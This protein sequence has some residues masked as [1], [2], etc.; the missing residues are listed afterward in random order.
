MTRSAR[1]ATPARQPQPSAAPRPAASSHGKPGAGAAP[2][3]LDNQAM[4]ALLRG[5]ELRAKMYVGAPDDPEERQAEATAER[6]M[7]APEADA[8]LPAASTAGIA[9]GTGGEPL[10]PGLR[11]FY[12]LRLGADFSNVRIY[13]DTAAQAAAA[14][15]GAHAFTL[16]QDIVF[17]AGQ[18]APERAEGRRLLAHELAHVERRLAGADRRGAIARAVDRSRADPLKK[19][20]DSLI[21]FNSRLERMWNEFGLDLPE[22]IAD[23]TPV[24]STPGKN[25]KPESYQDLWRRSVEVEKISQ[26]AAGRTLLS[27]FATDTVSFTKSHLSSQ[28]TRLE[29]LRAEL[30]RTEAQNRSAPPPTQSSAGGV[31]DPARKVSRS[32]VPKPMADVRN[33]VNTATL[34]HFLQSWDSLLRTAPIGVCQ[35]DGSGLL[36]PPGTPPPAP[37]FEPF[38]GPGGTLAA[39]A[40][41]GAGGAGGGA[42]GGQPARRLILF[43]PNKEKDALLTTPGLEFIDNAALEAL[44]RTWRACDEKRAEF[45]ELANTILAED[46]GLAVLAERGEL[47]MVSALSGHTDL[48]AFGAISRT[49]DDHIA[50]VQK[51]LRMVGSG[52]VDWKLL[53]PVHG[54]LL[55][56]GGGTGHD[57]LAPGRRSFVEEY[58]RRLEKARQD[59]ARTKMLIDLGFGAAAFIAMLTPAAPIA[60]AV[61]AASEVYAAANMA[62]SLSESFSASTKAEVTAAGAD[63]QVISK[64]TA[65]QAREEAERKKVLAAF[66]VLLVA[67]PYLPAAVRG[68]AR[69]TGVAAGVF[70]REATWAKLAEYSTRPLSALAPGGDIVVDLAKAGISAIA[71]NRVGGALSL[72]EM[73]AKIRVRSRTLPFVEVTPALTRGGDE[74]LL[75]PASAYGLKGYIRYHFQGPGT[76]LERYPIFEAP[77]LSNQFANNTIEGF[78][79]RHRDAGASVRFSPTYLTFSAE[80]MRPFVEGMLRSKDPTV[81]NRLALDYGRIEH[82][83]K[84]V[85]YDIIVV[86]NARTARY[87]AGIVIGPPPSGVVLVRTPPILV[88]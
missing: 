77:E 88:P 46:A 18:Y 80:E 72:N 27:A 2:S 29:N 3:L 16:G 13:R 65:R 74:R 85:S 30:K 48:E 37:D 82:F 69:A 6:V 56:G 43:D 38:G 47:A 81:L 76:G 7:R 60:A 31:E 57:W 40:A 23:T 67:L 1:A 52:E 34:V 68:G 12:E 79:R 59:A 83:L 39:G 71:R 49:T 20:L 61:I 14:S 32:T 22:A 17:G 19:E 8:L 84:E 75:R 24:T 86:Q 54:H 28:L 50:K 66:D 35:V 63:A 53:E 25:G 11:A 70:A 5:G 87:R 44:H 36:R 55:S 10:P 64:D 62:M 21:P 73:L 9:A 78:M 58:F 45:R 15:L 4:Q 33:M 42:T 51:F 26:T 41:S